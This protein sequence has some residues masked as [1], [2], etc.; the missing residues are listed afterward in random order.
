MKKFLLVTKT[1]GSS[2]PIYHENPEKYVKDLQK[3][4]PKFKCV[5]KEID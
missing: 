4:Y 3:R 5:I 2:K 1:H